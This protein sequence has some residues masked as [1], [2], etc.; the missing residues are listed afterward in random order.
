MS[1]TPLKE[2]SG[3]EQVDFSVFVEI[4]G[5]DVVDGGKLGFVGQVA[6]FVIPTRVYVE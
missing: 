3:G 1:G 5:D 4:V 2:V 6:H